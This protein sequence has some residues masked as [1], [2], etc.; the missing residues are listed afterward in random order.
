MPT[1]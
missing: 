1:S